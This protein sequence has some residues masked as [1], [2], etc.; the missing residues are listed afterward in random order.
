MT[1]C[2]YMHEAY[3]AGMWAFVSDFARID[4][5]NQYGGVYL[6]TDVELLKPLDEYLKY[7]LFAGW[8]KGGGSAVF[9]SRE[10]EKMF[11]VVNF[12]LGVGAVPGHPVL[13]DLIK[14]YQ[15]LPF[16]QPD[17]SMNLM[18]CPVYQTRV[19]LRY[20]LDATRQTLQ[21]NEHFAVFPPDYFSPKSFYTGL[22]EKTSNT[23]SI[24]H[25]SMSWKTKRELLEYWVYSRLARYMDQEK[26]YYWVRKQSARYD[27]WMGRIRKTLHI[28]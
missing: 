24:H 15:E 1:R 8:E 2:A 25:F 10:E 22:I 14:L 12:G 18:P 11:H 16:Y 7:P 4:I 9:G 23:V 26:A 21:R 28:K 13:Q 3:K 27:Y 5:L 19:M 6:D 17:G 20:G